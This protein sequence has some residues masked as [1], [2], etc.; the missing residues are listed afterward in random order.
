MCVEVLSSRTPTVFFCR[1]RS[2]FVGVIMA[3][4][5]YGLRLEGKVASY[6]RRGFF[7]LIAAEHIR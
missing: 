5:R 2:R 3:G 4:E 1:C 7:R 6:F